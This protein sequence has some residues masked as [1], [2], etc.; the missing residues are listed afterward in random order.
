MIVVVVIVSVGSARA[1][2][3]TATNRRCCCCCSAAIDF[4]SAIAA[5]DGCIVKETLSCYEL[6]KL[7][8]RL[9]CVIVLHIVVLSPLRWLKG[10]FFLILNYAF[11]CYCNDCAH[12]A[13]QS[14]SSLVSSQLALISSRSSLHERSPKAHRLNVGCVE[15]PHIDTGKI[16]RK[17]FPP[18]PDYMSHSI[19]RCTPT[20]RSQPCCLRV[21]WVLA[22]VVSSLRE[23]TR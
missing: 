10:T 13:Q 20:F 15:L 11:M 23:S 17:R 2:A 22:A 5:T 12:C 16:R 3:A 4:G 19:I 18:F 1:A 6:C 21:Y 8:L 9:F 7:T 14:T